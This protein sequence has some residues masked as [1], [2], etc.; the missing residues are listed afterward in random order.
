MN[1][2]RLMP[3]RVM[4]CQRRE[5]GEFPQGWLYEPKLDG[6]R[7][8]ALKAGGQVRLLSRH[9][10]EFTGKFPEVVSS[11]ATIPHDLTL[12]GEVAC[13]SHLQTAG[14]THLE[15]EWEIRWRAEHEPAT[16]H[17]FDILFLDGEWLLGLPLRERKGLLR[18]TVPDGGR[19]RVVEPQ[20]LETLVQ[21]A[22]RGEIEGLVAKHPDSPY[23]FRRSP[24]WLKFRPERTLE[25]PIVG[26][27][28]TDK[29]D[30]PFRSLIVRLPDGREGQ[31]SSGLSDAELALTDR[32]FR[33]VPSR[34]VG[35]RHYFVGDPGF[36]AEVKF[37]STP[38]EPFRFPRVVSLKLA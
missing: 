35:A 4:L 38:E 31:V 20:P 1:F 6:A 28:D 15:S 16:Y 34:A 23:E 9:G 13:A 11:L 32:I 14:R 12:D 18:R 8:L 3:E 27:E 21:M 2:W 19:V 36:T 17:A 24:H 22:E 5:W 33:G 26:W 7:C 29:P 30:R 25:L 10:T 37:Y